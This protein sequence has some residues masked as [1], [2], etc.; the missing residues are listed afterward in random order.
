MDFPT[1]V[2]SCLCGGDGN[3]IDTHRTHPPPQEY[4]DTPL[5][6]TEKPLLQ[7]APS[8]TPPDDAELNKPTT[9]ILSLLLT[10]PPLPPGTT[11]TPHITTTSLTTALAQRVLHAL[12]ATLQKADHES[13]GG[14]LRETYT[15]AVE[16]AKEELGLLWQY[17]QEHPY[18][19]AAEVLL[20]VLAL[21]VLGRLV[22]VLVRAL[23]FA[24]LGPVEGKYFF[25]FLLYCALP[26]RFGGCSWPVLV[27]WG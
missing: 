14:A 20:T 18:E 3:S 11:L 16:L 25:L 4:R 22:P 2:L 24:E 12:E 13:W 7:P 10:S 26:D 9:E 1:S 5:A 19:V 27:C 17:V 23:G 15:R 8:P 6:I 21:G